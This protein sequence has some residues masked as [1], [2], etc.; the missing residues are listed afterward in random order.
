[1]QSRS[2]A[3]AVSAGFTILTFS[4]HATICKGLKS[5]SNTYTYIWIQNMHYNKK[6]EAKSETAEMKFLQSAASYTRRDQIRC[7]K[8]REEL[9]I[10]TLNGKIIKSTSQW[11]YHVQQ[12]EDRF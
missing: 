8:I 1:L 3:T 6:Q 7:T 5:Y 4:R 12:M 9:N 2:L 11:K 10:F